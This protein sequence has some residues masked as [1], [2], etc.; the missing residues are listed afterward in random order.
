MRSAASTLRSHGVSAGDV[1]AIM[2]PNTI[3]LVVTLFAAWR[4]GALVTPLSPSLAPAEAT[5]QITDAD[6]KILIV[7]TPLN[8]D[9]RAVEIT[10][11][12]LTADGA[13]GDDVQHYDDSALALL[14]YTSGTTG[15][16]KGVMLDHANLIVDD[17]H[18]R[19]TPSSSPATITACS[20][21]RS[22][23]STASWSASVT[24]RRRRRPPPSRVASTPRRSSRPSKR[25]APRTSPQCRPSTPSWPACPTTSIPTRRRYASP[26]AVRRPCRP[27]SSG[28]FEDRYG[29]P[30]VEGYGLSECTCAG[31]DQPRARGRA[32]PARSGYLLPATRS[33][34]D[35]TGGNRPPTAG[36][37]GRGAGPERDARLPEPTGGNGEAAIVDGWLRTGD[38]GPL[39]EDGYLVLV[40]RAKDM[41]IRGGE[42]IYPK[43]IES[44]LYAPPRRRSRPPSSAGPTPCTARSRSPS[45]RCAGQVQPPP[46][47]CSP[48]RRTS[49]A[50]Y[51]VP[52]HLHPRSLP[53]NPLGKIDKPTLRRSIAE[54]R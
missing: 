12:G 53:K 5:Y 46:T 25:C 11:G 52:R 50:K 1:A 2:L 38:V 32:S 3:D 16:P 23:T 37:R 29:L 6:A 10:T 15:S 26:S 18:D 28:R 41:I 35:D 8:L 30:I 34:I 31:H 22:S 21:C 49:L 19:S 44:V 4:L 40:D 7:T 27:S 24:A 45:W 47:S 36:R 33:R 13:S 20:S 14:I 9:A 43:E 48:V 17:R 51:K 42:N 54:N 39:D